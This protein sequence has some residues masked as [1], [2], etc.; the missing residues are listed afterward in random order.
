MHITGR[1][2][3]H[4]FQTV[5]GEMRRIRSEIPTMDER[6]AIHTRAHTYVSICEPRALWI[7][8]TNLR[9]WS[10]IDANVCGNTLYMYVVYVLQPTREC[11]LPVHDTPNSLVHNYPNGSVY[12]NVISR[13]DTK[14]KLTTK[15]T[16]LSSALEGEN[17][18]GETISLSIFSN[19]WTEPGPCQPSK[20]F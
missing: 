13:W 2:N 20:T 11:S 1:S 18:D 12:T 3:S 16:Y 17:F 9:L 14:V 10:N 6:F 4:L 8:V 7:V 19:V 15:N 5:K